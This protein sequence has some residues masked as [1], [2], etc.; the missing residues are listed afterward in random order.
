MSKSNIWENELLLLLFN[1]TNST[2]H[3]DATGLRGSSTEGQYF[4][5]LHTADPGESGIQST[6]E[7]TYGS[8]VR[9]GVNRNSGSFVVSNNTVA[10]A[11]PVTF[12]TGSSGS[13]VCT[14]FGLGCSSTG[15]GK[16]LYKGTLN[17]NLTVGAGIPPVINAGVVVTEE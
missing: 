16:L 5:S 1:N 9:V 3:G 12:A 17:P 8:Y 13:Q 4:V 15:T 11:A 10:F 2:L 14:H 7:T 6:N